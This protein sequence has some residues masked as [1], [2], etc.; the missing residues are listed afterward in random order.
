MDNAKLKEIRAALRDGSL[1]SAN[2]QTLKEDLKELYQVQRLAEWVNERDELINAIQYLIELKESGK[3]QSKAI[4]QNWWI[5]I[6][7]GLTLAATLVFG[8]WTIHHDIS[9]SSTPQSSVINPSPKLP[10]AESSVPLTDLTPKTNT[11]SK[12][13]LQPKNTQPAT[14]GPALT[15]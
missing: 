2:I 6:I 12:S 10:Q 1:E 15:K 4:C 13:V 8:I 14:N 7:A 5:L 11:Q 9:E 3:G